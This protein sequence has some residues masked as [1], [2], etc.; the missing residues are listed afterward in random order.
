MLHGATDGGAAVSHRRGRS[1]RE[2][3]P[4]GWIDA[5]AP[6]LLLHHRHGE[7]HLPPTA[8][9]PRYQLHIRRPARTH[10]ATSCGA[11]HRLF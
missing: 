2:V 9:C 8:R 4:A 7:P 11:Q 6:V 3:P 5:G 10:R 1:S